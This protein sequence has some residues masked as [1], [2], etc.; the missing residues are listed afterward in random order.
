MDMHKIFNA[1]FDQGYFRNCVRK[2]KEEKMNIKK[3]NKNTLD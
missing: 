3:L 1:D 2:I